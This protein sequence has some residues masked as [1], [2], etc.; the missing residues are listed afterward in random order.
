MYYED[1]LENV[2]NMNDDVS[3]DF[4]LGKEGLKRSEK[5]YEKYRYSE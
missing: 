3:V 2:V 1:L 4:K 5:H